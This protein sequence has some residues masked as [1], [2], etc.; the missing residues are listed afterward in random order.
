VAPEF[1][2]AIVTALQAK[3]TAAAVVGQVVAPQEKTVIYS[4][5]PA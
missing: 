5:E 4:P 3:F 1:S 2:H